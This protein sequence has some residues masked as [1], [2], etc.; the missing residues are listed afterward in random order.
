[1]AKTQRRVAGETLVTDTQRIVI[2]NRKNIFTALRKI[3]KLSYLF[4]TILFLSNLISLINQIY[5]NTIF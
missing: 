5:K 2:K 3:S 1:M 4:V